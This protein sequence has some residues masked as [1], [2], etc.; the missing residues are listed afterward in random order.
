MSES[1]YLEAGQSY[2]FTNFSHQTGALI[3]IYQADRMSML[4]LSEISLGSSNG[5]IDFSGMLLVVSL[6]LGSATHTEIPTGYRA[7]TSAK[8]GNL[9]FLESLDVRR[10]GLV[11]VDGSGC[12]RLRKLDARDSAVETFSVA[13]TSPINDIAM[14]G[15][16]TEVSLVGLPNL[17]YTGLNAVAGLRVPSLSKVQK[18]RLETSPKLDARRMLNDT[19]DGQASAPLLSALRFN[20]MPLKGDASELQ[21]VIARGVAGLDSD[22]NRVALPVINADYQLTTI[23]DEAEIERIESSFEGLTLCTVI[24]AF[25]ELID[26]VNGEFFSGDAEVDTV[27]L[28]NIGDTLVYYNGETYEDYIA[29]I[30]EYNRSIHEIINL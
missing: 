13:E 7:M 9:P 5:E 27:T 22:G 19:L 28:D 11:A 8:L 12:P 14:P 24:D 6:I 17:T 29:R 21:T 2:E 23:L 20:E 4:D 15:S 25:I 30:A 18:L 3:Y 16:L 10:T 1:V 26:I